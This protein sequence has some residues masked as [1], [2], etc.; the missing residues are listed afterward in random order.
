M[1]QHYSIVSIEG[2]GD[3]IMFLSELG[4]IIIII[5]LSKNIE[6]DDDDAMQCLL[7]GYVSSKEHPSIL[8]AQL[9]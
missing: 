1:T 8:L 2:H 7:Y 4:S 5:K 3:I 6:H 9:N